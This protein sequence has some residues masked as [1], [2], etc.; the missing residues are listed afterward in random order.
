VSN[1]GTARKARRASYATAKHRGHRSHDQDS[2]SLLQY[3]LS[4][5][6]DRNTTA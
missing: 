5:L 6:S 1:G 4:I 3:V 2:E